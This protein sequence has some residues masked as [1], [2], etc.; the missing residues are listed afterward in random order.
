MKMS[1]YTKPWLR[2]YYNAKRRCKE[3]KSYIKNGIQVKITPDEI[4]QLWVRDKAENMKCP[5]ISRVDHSKN[6]TLENCCFRERSEHFRDAKPG[7]WKA[8]YSI[9]SNGLTKEYHSMTYASEC[10]GV[11]IKC[12]FR[13]Y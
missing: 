8:V 2:V 3:N 4:K 12:Y 10:M 7:N 5:T 1:N 9:D 13:G 11:T 6:Y